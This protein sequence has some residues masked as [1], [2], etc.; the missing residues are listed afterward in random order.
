MTEHVVH[1][2]R[3]R[4]SQEEL[5]Q[6]VDYYTA[7]AYSSGYPSATDVVSN[8]PRMSFLET[9]FH[10]EEPVASSGSRPMVCPELKAVA[11][12]RQIVQKFLKP[13]DIIVH[14]CIGTVATAKACLINPK[15]CKFTGCDSDSDFLSKMRPSLLETFTLQ[16]LNKN[17]NNVESAEIAKAASS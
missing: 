5:L 17:F 6:A 1:F 7:P 16:V 14:P 13:E 4:P 10:I 12:M 2:W 3:L 8:I 11:V 9:V 15:H